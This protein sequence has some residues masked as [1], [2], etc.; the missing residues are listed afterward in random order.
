MLDN[1][2]DPVVQDYLFYDFRRKSIE[3]AAQLQSLATDVNELGETSSDL[4]EAIDEAEALADLYMGLVNR[5]LAYADPDVRDFYG[6]QLDAVEVNPQL[7]TRE[8]LQLHATLVA[9]P[10]GSELRSL[11]GLLTDSEVDALWAALTNGSDLARLQ[12]V[13]EVTPIVVRCNTQRPTLNLTEDIESLRSFEAPQL[14]TPKGLISVA[15]MEVGCELYDV[16]PQEATEPN[17]VTLDIVPTLVM[18]GG[19]DHATPMEWGE[20]AFETLGDA[21]MITVPL[22]DRR[23]PLFQM[24]QRPCPYVLS[25]PGNGAEHIL[26]TPVCARLY[27]AR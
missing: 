20:V 17:A 3:L 19:T 13:E 7:K 24:C 9:E 21:R 10:V 14:I 15:T 18:N 1:L 12:F 8:G 5:Y 4:T 11:I 27:L 2:I 6:R 22:T 26:H 25:Q 23:D 16:G